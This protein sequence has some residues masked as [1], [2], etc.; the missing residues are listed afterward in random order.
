MNPIQAA[1]KQTM[2]D[3]RLAMRDW[4]TA[5]TDPGTPI[6]DENQRAP[7]PVYPYVSFGFLGTMTKIGRADS[8]VYDPEANVFRL[9]AHRSATV[10]VNA[11]GKPYS[12]SYNALVRATDVLSGIQM[13]IDEPFAYAKLAQK[14]FAILGDNGVIDTTVYEDNLWQP[15]AN[16]DLIIGLSI[17]AN[18]PLSWI[19][20]IEVTSKY[21]ANFDGD[22]E[23][24]FGPFIFTDSPE[25]S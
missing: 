18:I 1:I 25:D 21:D 23:K 5:A 12:G 22:F 20:T 13:H 2:N 11:H 7:Q 9:R 16:L 15:R 3:L 14:N 4:L 8:S 24:V 6:V 10:T 17:A 19:E